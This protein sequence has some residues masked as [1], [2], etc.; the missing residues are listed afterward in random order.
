MLKPSFIAKLLGT[1]AS[2]PRSWN[3]AVMRSGSG[4]DGAAPP[5]S[6]ELGV[7]SFSSWV[8]AAA[9]I[10]ANAVAALPL[11]LYIRNGG[12]RTKLWRT[13]RVENERKAYLLG[14]G[15]MRP[16]VA[17]MR[18][19]AE[20]GSD[21]EEVTDDHPLLRLLSVSNPWLNGFDATV[22]R[23]VWQELTG[24]AYLHVV[25]DPSMGVPSQLYPM[26]PQWTRIIPSEERFV[27]GYVYGRSRESEVRF[28]PEEVIHFK[29]PNPRDLLYGMGKLEAAWG[30]AA[31]NTALHEMD[32]STFKNQGRPDYLV[33]IKGS[34]SEDDM[35]VFEEQL[36][37]KLQGTRKSGSF[38]IANQEIDLK[39]LQFP[40]KDITGREAV[41]EEIAAVFGV[42]VSML[43]ANDPNLASAQT[44]FTSWREMTVLP[45][46]RMDEEILNQRLLPMFGLEGD[47]ILAYDNP[48]PSNRQQ[49]LAERQAAVSGGW[50][51]ANEARQEQGL[52]ALPDPEADKLHVGG[53]P[54][55]G[56]PAQ[57]AQGTGGEALPALDGGAGQLPSPAPATP[58]SPTEA[59]Q[60]AAGQPVANTALNGAQISS[61][62]TLAAQA[63]SGELPL[64][65]ARAIAAA[66]FPS[67]PQTV[68]DS[69][70]SPIVPSSAPPAPAA[71]AAVTPTKAND[72]SVKADP[73]Q[74]CVSAKI[75]K[76]I[77]EGYPHEQAI[78]I[79][80]QMC[81]SGKAAP[82]CSC[83]SSVSI[84]AA[85]MEIKNCGTGDGGFQA[86]NECGGGDG[87]GSSDAPS[88]SQKPKTIPDDIA[89]HGAA[90]DHETMKADVS[91]IIDSFGSIDAPE[92]VQ[93]ALRDVAVKVQGD[94]N[95]TVDGLM[96]RDP[97]GRP[98]ET[99]NAVRMAVASAF[100]HGGDAEA[101]RVST[102]IAEKFESISERS[103]VLIKKYPD[104]GRKDPELAARAAHAIV[105]AQSVCVR[106]AGVVELDM[107]SAEEWKSSYQQ[108]NVQADAWYRFIDNKIAH[109]PNAD[110]MRI[111]EK[112]I[113]HE[114]AHAHHMYGA[115]RATMTPVAIS[116]RKPLS[117]DEKATALV[118]GVRHYGTTNR[119]EFVAVVHEMISQGH[120]VTPECWKLY[121]KFNGP[122][123]RPELRKARTMRKV[124]A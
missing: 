118:G 18:K 8:Y 117:A 115:K 120:S 123:V 95:R 29:R 10:N 60:P 92:A 91:K 54:L 79:A 42:P 112:N 78:A 33:S 119:L 101:T 36:K 84:A 116:Q 44:G 53:Q 43:K 107:P 58:P 87:G 94:F 89:Y 17:V 21:F 96:S 22:L 4:K 30:V 15:R 110:S 5:F 16:S 97:V 61:L 32:L 62:V 80:F 90:M 104:G 45:L 85:A 65:S 86:G 74:E 105:A 109:N 1:K 9:S 124:T 88:S 73:L 66:A 82:P 7:R 49:D 98:T 99:I 23:V 31:A 52:D 46:A 55:G 34:A 39:P 103:G 47:A 57:P 111:F 76:L 56:Q 77:G 14:D 102:A 48:V 75:S 37:D 28:T 11:R 64:E 27:E 63:K 121:D 113:A 70:F 51:T 67:I 26:P 122:E 3:H 71:P 12:S 106:S 2:S 38:L 35:A 83:G 114:L 93:V 108:A 24:N 19:A 69:I 81:Q 50:M 68:I 40:P 41:V 72:F 59:P 20:I 6:H 25:T 13:R 100:E